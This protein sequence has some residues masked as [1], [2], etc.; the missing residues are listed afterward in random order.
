VTDKLDTHFNDSDSC[1]QTV[2]TPSAAC[3][4]TASSNGSTISLETSNK[5][6]DVSLPYQST[7]GAGGRVINNEEAR[8]LIVD[9]QINIDGSHEIEDFSSTFNKTSPTLENSDAKPVT[10][11]S[12]RCTKRF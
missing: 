7:A 12:Q 10:P 8:A 3:D 11:L 4:Q 5:K 6:I 9:G 1:G 2:I